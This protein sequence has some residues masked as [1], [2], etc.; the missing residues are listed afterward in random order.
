MSLKKQ[1]TTFFSVLMAVYNDEKFLPLALKSILDQNYVNYE[2]VIVD[3]CSTDATAAILEKYKSI[4]NKCKILRNP[5]NRGLGASLAAGL[6]ICKG[7]YVM[8]L[9]SDDLCFDNRM[10][11]ASNF[12]SCNPSVDIIGSS[13]VVIDGSGNKLGL[14]AVPIYHDDIV[15]KIWACPIIHPSVFFKKSAIN[16][17]GGYNSNIGRCCDY[18]LWFKSVQANLKFHN[19]V[20]PLIYYR[21]DINTHRKNSL[22]HLFEQ[23]KI[24]LRWCWKLK[25]SYWKYLAVMYPLIRGIMPIK[26]RAYLYR[27]SR[28]Y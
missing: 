10:K 24:G 7:E 8:R 1:K 9:D 4:F 28:A 6:K 14:K 11:E 5:I 21:H 15:N 23:A 18:D 16:I 12:I 17:L 19:M 27:I 13:A 3:D 26:L 25:L 20:E 22:R 2:V